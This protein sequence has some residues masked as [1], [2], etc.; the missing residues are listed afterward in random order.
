M[1]SRL[2]HLKDL[3]GVAARSAAALEEARAGA[4]RAGHAGAGS[5][6]SQPS[7]SLYSD[8]VEAPRALNSH[9]FTGK[10]RIPN[11]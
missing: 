3:E 4:G 11:L 8:L 5:T 9:N 6:V 10:V 7:G 2:R 1:S